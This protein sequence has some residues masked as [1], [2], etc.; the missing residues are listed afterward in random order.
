MAHLGM[1]R[2][3]E[4][5]GNV[6]DI[7]G[8]D[9]YGPDDQRLGEIDDIIFDHAT[10][11]IRYLVVDT[12]GWLSSNKFIVPA[13]RIQPYH[14]NQDDFYTD[15][16]KER[17]E[18]FPAYDEKLLDKRDAWAD[19]ERKY[20]NAWTE[21]PVMHREGSPN[22]ITPPAGEIEPVETGRA[23]VANAGTVT[24]SANLTPERIRD[25]FEPAKMPQSTLH[26][27]ESTRTGVPA[28]Q[29]NPVTGRLN[30]FQENIRNTRTRWSEG[31]AECRKAA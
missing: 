8:A 3:Y 12:G 25:K 26:P 9:L 27:T 14:R 20:E 28:P 1:L 4:F 21:E 31:C 7:R 29:A 13:N 16:S 5:E 15:L 18:M 11:D 6:D 22:I 10:G 30:T 17:I 19:Y 2:D 24:S 23:P